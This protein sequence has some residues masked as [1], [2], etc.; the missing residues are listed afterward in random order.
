MPLSRTRIFPPKCKH[1]GNKVRRKGQRQICVQTVWGASK[2][3]VQRWQCCSCGAYSQSYPPGLDGSGWSP[4]ALQRILDLCVRLPYREAQAALELQ[5]L[6]LL[7]SHCERLTQSYGACAQARMEQRLSELSEQS[8]SRS[9]GQV[10]VVQ[11]D[12]V[13]VIEKNKPIKGQC[14]GREVK[15][16][17]V[18]PLVAP[19]SRCSIASAAPVAAFAPLAHGLVRHGGCVERTP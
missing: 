1:C 9:S 15:Q 5:G 7:P 10:M 6:E 2:V 13:Y 4:K 8:L 17:L 18:Y 3:Y 16:I 12:G 11:A 19:Q 14:E